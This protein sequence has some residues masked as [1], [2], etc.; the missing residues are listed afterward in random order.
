MPVE[1]LKSVNIILDIFPVLIEDQAVDPRP[2]KVHQSSSA[3]KVFWLRSIILFSLLSRSV[4]VCLLSVALFPIYLPGSPKIPGSVGRHS[5]AT[6]WTIFSSV[7]VRPVE[8]RHGKV[9]RRIGIMGS[10]H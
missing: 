4:I 6:R 7:V 8:I 10:V 2:A 1:T 9:I 3:R 5:L